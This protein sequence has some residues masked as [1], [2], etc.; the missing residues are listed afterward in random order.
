[1]KV[2][3]E[4]DAAEEIDKVVRDKEWWEELKERLGNTEAALLELLKHCQ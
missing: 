3:R 2:K 4:T 1:L